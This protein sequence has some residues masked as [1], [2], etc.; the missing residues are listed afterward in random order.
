MGGAKISGILKKKKKGPKL[1]TVS[2]SMLQFIT[3]LSK[4]IPLLFY[5]TALNSSLQ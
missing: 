5:R 3:L 1:H 4:M 2:N